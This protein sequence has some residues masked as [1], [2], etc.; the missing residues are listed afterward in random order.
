MKARGIKTA[1]PGHHKTRKDRQIEAA[2]RKA[3]AET[4]K[5]QADRHRAK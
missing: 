2:A 1:P 3:A 4:S 5:Q